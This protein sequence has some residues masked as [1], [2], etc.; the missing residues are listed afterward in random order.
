MLGMSACSILQVLAPPPP[1]AAPPP[2]PPPPPPPPPFESSA[3]PGRVYAE[4]AR[5][6]SAHGYK[7]F[8][9]AALAEHANIESGFRPCAVGP[10]GY[11]YLFQWAGLRLRRLH[12]FAGGPGC[13]SVE[14]QLE[15][16][17]KELRNDP[18]YAC[19]WDATTPRAAL[20]ALRRGFGGGSDASAAGAR[21]RWPVAR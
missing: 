2:S 15:F 4:L 7:E 18:K 1:P 17:D 10:G 9:V 16:A 3:P 13:P 20:T 19:F 14:T 11:H 21:L 6:F 5:W 8:Q 12:E